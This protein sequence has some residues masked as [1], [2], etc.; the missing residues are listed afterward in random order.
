[1]ASQMTPA[2]PTINGAPHAAID[3]EMTGPTL[4]RR[5]VNGRSRPPWA[6]AGVIPKKSSE[7]KNR[8]YSP[9]ASDPPSND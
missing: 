9:D 8:R 6:L 1:M 2:P 4:E 3:L 5:Q 7:G